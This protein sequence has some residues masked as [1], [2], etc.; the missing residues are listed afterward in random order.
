M[1]KR[2]VWNSKLLLVMLGVSLGLIAR[3][4]LGVPDD[5]NGIDRKFTDPLPADLLE[6]TPQQELDLPLDPDLLGK[7]SQGLVPPIQMPTPFEMAGDSPSPVAFTAYQGDDEDEWATF[8]PHGELVCASGCSL[9]RHPTSELTTSRFEELIAELAEG[10]MEGSNEALETLLYFGRQTS[11]KIEQ[12]GFELEESRLEFLQKE[13]LLTH[14]NIQIRVVDQS[15]VVRSWLPESRVPLDRR[16][17]FEM[18]TENVQPLV[19]SGTVKRVGLNHAWV[20][21]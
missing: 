6:K 8:E 13:L 11:E 12:G 1:A 19:T 9:S 17:V 14:A 7:N 10:P 21:L 15:G 2:S 18:K 20:R 16:H 4:V 3:A 5:G